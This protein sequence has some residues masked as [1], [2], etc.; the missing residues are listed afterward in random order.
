MNQQARNFLLEGA[1]LADL[2]L[3]AGVLTVS[4][5]HDFGPRWLGG[6]LLVERPLVQ[7]A[8]GL[9]LVSGWHLSFVVVGAYRS[10]RLS[11]PSQLA[12]MLGKGTLMAALCAALWSLAHALPFGAAGFS[13]PLFALQIGDF[14][15]LTF[16]LLLLS[17]MGGQVQHAVD[18][19]PGPE[20]AICADGRH[21]FTGCCHGRVY[22]P[23]LLT[24]LPPDGLCR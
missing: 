2:V 14:A 22:D 3:C 24:R 6:T 12:M 1:M 13:F 19:A 23:A 10:Q 16:V 21:K 17:R 11:T 8:L 20:P 4:S 7:I 5:V 9:M 15:A 18:A